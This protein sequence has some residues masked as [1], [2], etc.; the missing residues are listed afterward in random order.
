M[1]LGEENGICWSKR[2]KVPENFESTNGFRYGMD[3]QVVLITWTKEVINFKR[4]L[5]LNQSYQSW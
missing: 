4:D 2:K 5:G 1:V 3:T